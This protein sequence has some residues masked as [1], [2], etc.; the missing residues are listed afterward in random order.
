MK[1]VILCGGLGTRFSEETKTKPKPM[2]KIGK[3]PILFHIMK[4]Y[5]KHGINDFIL[6]LGY[7][8]SFIKN[9]F[10][11]KN[12][13]NFNKDYYRY[14]KQ[15]PKKLNW[16][17]DFCFS[18]LKTMTGG[19]LLRLKK[20][21]KND[22]NFL[23]TYGDGLANVN[24]KK[25]VKYHNSNKKIAT[26]TAVIPSARF[27]ALK[28]SGNKVLNF[29]E[30]PQSGE[31]WI[32]GGFFCFNK[33]IFNYIEGDKTVLEDSPLTNLAKKKQLVAFKHKNFWQCMD[34]R[35]DHDLLVNQWRGRKILWLKN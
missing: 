6:A 19:R 2:I 13:N 24:I 20:F 21:L 5:E 11:Q 9:Y 26:V 31:G 34:T 18:G 1:A 27:G 35:R 28:I 14:L 33:K 25:L 29:Q 32:N 30:K 10:N 23:C 17:I 16:K 22:E 8:G 3:Y 15:K 12:L 4:I 7:K